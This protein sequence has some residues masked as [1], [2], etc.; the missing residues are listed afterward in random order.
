MTKKFLFSFKILQFYLVYL[1]RLSSLGLEFDDDETRLVHDLLLSNYNK[2]VR[3]T[4]DK[5]L[6]IEV[7]FGIAY[8]QIVDLVN[9]FVNLT[10]SV[11]CDIQS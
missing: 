1:N 8:T 6:P 10:I 9:Q 2:N 4:Q 3:P 5:E 11:P 7:K